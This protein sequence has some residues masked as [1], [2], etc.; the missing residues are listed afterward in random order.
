[1]IHNI[2]TVS[3]YIEQIEKLINNKKHNYYFRGQDD[4]FSNTL[5]AIFRSRKLLDNEDNLFNDFLMTDP[6]LFEKCRTNFERLA[7]MEHYH[8]PTRLL[9]VSSNPLIALF[10]AVKGG[11]GNGEV[12]I[13]KDR[14]NS[15]KLAKMLDER[16]WHNLIAEYESK[17][18]LTSHNYF[19]KNAFSNEMQLESSLARQSFTDKAVFFQSIK[20]FYKLDNDYIA[21]QHK[22]WSHSYDSY[23]NNNQDSNYFVKFKRD[24]QTLPFLR[25]FE[26]AKRDIPSF[27]NKLNPLELIVP[28]I[29][30]IKRMSRRM[31]N[32]Q[33]LFL[34]VPFIGE[35]YDSSVDINYSEVERRAQLAIDI[36]SLYNPDN[37]NE[38]EKYIIPAEYKRP[39]LDELAKLG[40]D[41]SFIYPE[42]HAKKAEMI[43]AKYL[44]F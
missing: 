31:E 11:K 39:I 20:N 14:P 9:D 27:S 7:L 17:N 15:D 43:K 33:G 32:Q 2:K 38:K 36:L 44:G 30:T 8:L 3:N 26:E 6:Q 24:L 4:A 29:V 41:Y 10:F 18:E 13:Y 34:F 12:Y 22:L 1:M 28:K 40:I 19:K 42:D 37:P 25:L 23:F 35:E 5:P 16:G 21:Q